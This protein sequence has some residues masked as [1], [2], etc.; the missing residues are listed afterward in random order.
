VVTTEEEA[1]VE[2]V[3]TTEVRWKSDGL[4][5]REAVL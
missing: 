3:G 5:G 4:G 1:E 2:E